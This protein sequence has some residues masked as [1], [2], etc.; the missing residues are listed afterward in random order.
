MTE[1]L[2][3]ALSD[4]PLRTGYIEALATVSTA[5]G[6]VARLEAGLHPWQGV[7][8]FAFGEVDREQ[9]VAGVGARVEFGPR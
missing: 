3:K 6:P 7:G 2:K 8:V 1:G 9:A 4:V 5:R